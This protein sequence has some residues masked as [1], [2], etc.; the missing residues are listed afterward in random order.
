[1]SHEFHKETYKDCTI[2]IVQDEH[3]CD[4]RKDYDHIGTLSPYDEPGYN[5]SLSQEQRE[6]FMWGLAEKQITIREKLAGITYA[7]AY[8]NWLES[9]D[10]SDE[11]VYPVH[12]ELIDMAL[13]DNVIVPYDYYEHGCQTSFAEAKDWDNCSGYA[14]MSMDTA[15]KNWS[16]TDDEVRKSAEA[17]LRA[18]LTELDNWAQGNV[19]G[20]IAETP[21][22]ETIE[23]VWGYY[24]DEYP[25]EWDYPISEARSHIDQWHADQHELET[26]LCMNI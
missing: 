10:G 12:D 22:G 24:P 9:D 21:D 18:E 15:R 20:W 23:S 5:S 11:M 6:D 14:W 1:M 26:Q 16:G 13:V 25:K 2:R 3:P 17:C 8:S 7:N 4:P 19:A